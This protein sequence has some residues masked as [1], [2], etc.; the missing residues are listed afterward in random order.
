MIRGFALFG[1]L[2]VNMFNFGAFSP[3]WT[4]AGDRFAFALMHV[5]F[6]TKS[7]RLFAL[8]F[9][10]GFSIQLIRAE[11]RGTRFVPTYL[12]RLAVLFLIG[13]AHALLFAADVLMIYAELGLLLLVLRRAP[14]RLLLVLAIALLAVFPLGRA[15]NAAVDPNVT[16]TAR[17]VNLERARAV[18]E[19]LRR[20]H[21]YA[22]GSAMDVLRA[23][24]RTI[25][26]NPLGGPL[27]AES[28]LGFLA[29]FLLGLY[30]G[31]RGIFTDVDRHSAVFRRGAALGLTLGLSAMALE[32]AITLGAG[33]PGGDSGTGP[34][35]GL[36]RDLSFT[37]GSTVLCLGYAS[38]V[39]LLARQSRLRWFLERLGFV[40]RLALTVYLT[41]TLAFTTIFYG[42]GLGQAFRM[43][44]ARVTAIAIV[45]F[46]LQF[47]AC[48][49]WVRRFR[50]GPVEWLWRGLTY[51]RFPPMRL[52][53]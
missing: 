49:W 29:M 1:V 39:V 2:L 36:L 12:R 40:G 4:G 13:V 46:G 47:A 43:G 33:D 6:E 9:G 42:Y 53:T 52:G 38:T 15:A 41:Q 48:A 34:A 25:P 51:L 19:E 23:N 37:Y 16:A 5:F 45:I 28:G 27:G 32:R 35:L 22:V 11:E 8:L 31:R 20:T 7:W 24:A 50:Y 30:V 14:P 18:N 44:P 21:P 26:A 3:I 17:T 10:L